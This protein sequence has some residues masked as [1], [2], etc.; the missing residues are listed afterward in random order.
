MKKVLLVIVSC[1]VFFSSLPAFSEYGEEYTGDE[2]Y[3]VGISEDL[4]VCPNGEVAVRSGG[5]YVTPDGR[6]SP[7]LDDD[8]WYDSG[9]DS[10]DGEEW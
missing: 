5:G 3:C 9:S 4:A 2:G 7:A 1:S 8:D 10:D 6:Y